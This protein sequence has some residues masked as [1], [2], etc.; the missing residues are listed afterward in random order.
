MA[1][2]DAQ[3][4]EHKDKRK[5]TRSKICEDFFEFLSVFWY[6]LSP[7]AVYTTHVSCYWRDMSIAAQFLIGCLLPSVQQ[8]QA[9]TAPFHTDQT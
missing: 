1:S 4:Q 9:N 3:S 7:A 6:F 5:K 8:Q 2:W